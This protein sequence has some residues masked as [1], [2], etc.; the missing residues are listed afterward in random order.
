MSWIVLTSYTVIF[1]LITYLIWRKVDPETKPHRDPLM[2]L[3]LALVSVVIWGI[4]WV[5]HLANWY[6]GFEG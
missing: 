4:Y 6:W 5:Y 2:P 1:G 3:L